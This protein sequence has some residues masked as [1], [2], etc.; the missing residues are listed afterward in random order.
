M[1]TLQ[2][3]AKLAIHWDIENNLVPTTSAIDEALQLA[4]TNCFSKVLPENQ[5]EQ[6]QVILKTLLAVKDMLKSENFLH[7]SSIIVQHSNLALETDGIALA[8]ICESENKPFVC[9]KGCTGCCHQMVMCTPTEAFL[10][11]A[12]LQSMPQIMENFTENWIVWHEQTKELRKTYSAWAKKFYGEGVDDGSHKVEDYYIPCPFLYA[13][14]LC[15]IY[16]VRPYGCRSS[17]SVE[18]SC[19]KAN[20]EGQAGRQN[21]HYSLFTGHH[22]VRQ[23]VLQVIADFAKEDVAYQESFGEIEKLSKDCAMPEIVARILN[24]E[25]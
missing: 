11:A 18:N 16:A 10:I 1:D 4:I 8:K 7:Q 25:F 23:K 24:L 15:Q 5:A 13:D 2:N 3:N 17:V 6:D 19:P 12:Y 21:I 20:E 22:A 14:G 9:K